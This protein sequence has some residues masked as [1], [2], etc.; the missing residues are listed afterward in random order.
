VIELLTVIVIVGILAGIAVPAF[1]HHRDRARDAQAKASVRAAQ[2]AAMEVSADNGGRFD[3]PDGVTV[4]NLEAED[5][6]LVDASLTVP[7]ALA[8]TYTVRVQSETGN[9]FDVTQT[10]SGTTDLTCASADD[11]GCPADGTWD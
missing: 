1:F 2:S 9:T 8:D 6:S 7:L 10:E 3:G 4:Q 11:A 5:P